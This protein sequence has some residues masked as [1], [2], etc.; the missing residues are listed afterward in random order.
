MPVELAPW[1]MRRQPMTSLEAYRQS[2]SERARVE[3]LLGL[4]PQHGATALDVG[5]RDGFLSRLLADRFERVIALDLK[6]PDIVHPRIECVQGDASRLPYEDRSFDAVLCAEVLEHIPRPTLELVCHELVRVTRTTLVIGVPFAQDLRCGE[7]TCSSCGGFNP[8]WGHVNSFDESNLRQLFAAMSP[9]RIG[10]V[11]STSDCT[12]AFSS[13]FMRIAGNPYGTYEQDESCV[14]CGAAIGAARL[15][16]LPQKVATKLAVLG[17]RVQ[18][19]LRPPKPMWIH[20]QFG[21][22]GD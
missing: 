20:M 19:A 17:N 12:N 3:D 11:W 16:S 2:Q 13:A 6:R 21:H 4:L 18:R 8:P 22:A 1:S 7:T 10:F 9:R 15:R 5:A 14:H